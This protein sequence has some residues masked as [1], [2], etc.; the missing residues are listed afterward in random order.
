MGV[1]ASSQKVPKAEGEEGVKKREEKKRTDGGEKA[2]SIARNRTSS[3][4]R[5]LSQTP[6]AGR[7]LWRTKK[8][9][10]WALKIG[11]LRIA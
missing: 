11:S 7:K 4:E 1:G 3:E 9:E 2:L 6:H 10:K 8:R 5:G